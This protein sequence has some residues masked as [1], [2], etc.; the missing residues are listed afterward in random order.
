MILKLI[1]LSLH[2]KNIIMAKQLTLKTIE[3]FKLPQNKIQPD[4]D[5]FGYEFTL[6][7][8]IVLTTL[9]V[10]SGLP[11]KSDSL[12]GLD[13]YIYITT[14]EELEH[15]ISLSYEEILKEVQEENEDFDITEYM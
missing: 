2:S 7:S 4:Y 13:G 8:G 3:K 5:D 10:C 14:K 11:C 15:L 6:P 1:L 9:F 12:E